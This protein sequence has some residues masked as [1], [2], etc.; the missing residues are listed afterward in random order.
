M[1]PEY[2]LRLRSPGLVGQIARRVTVAS[3]KNAPWANIPD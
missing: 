1:N 3:R 2:R